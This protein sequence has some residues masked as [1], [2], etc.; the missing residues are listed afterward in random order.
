M[1]CGPGDARRARDAFYG[2]LLSPTPNVRAIDPRIIK[3]TEFYFRN[4]ERDVDVAEVAGHVALS[5]AHFSRLFSKTVG[6]PP[7]RYRLW[8]RALE[9]A[10]L[11]LQGKSVTEA[12]HGAGFADAAHFTRTYNRLMGSGGPRANMENMEVVICD[13]RWLGAPPAIG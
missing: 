10:R 4:R 3:A 12:A 2:T 8:M 11:V 6:V 7:S 5:Q 1:A 9:A 13:D